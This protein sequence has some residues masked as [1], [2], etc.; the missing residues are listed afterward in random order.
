MDGSVGPDILLGTAGGRLVWRISPLQ[1]PES[2]RRTLCLLCID[3][4]LLRKWY[5]RVYYRAGCQACWHPRG[6]CA[7]GGGRVIAFTSIDRETVAAASTPDKRHTHTVRSLA[8]A[9]RSPTALPSFYC[10]TQSFQ[11]HARWPWPVGEELALAGVF[12]EDS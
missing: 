2:P 6:F 3:L 10:A 8:Q 5:F 7:Q 11:V 4:C 9:C 1:R 12:R